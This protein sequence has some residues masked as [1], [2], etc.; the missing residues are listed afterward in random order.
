MLAI[1]WNVKGLGRKEKCKM[2]RNLVLKYKSVVLF[3]Q[4]TKLSSFDSGVIRALGGDVLSRGN[5]V[6]SVGALGGLLSLWNDS[7]FVVNSCVPSK[8]CFFLFG[9]LL[10]IKKVLGMIWDSVVLGVNGVVLQGVL[11]CF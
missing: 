6:G 10:G 3:L 2:V 1:S 4:E 5:G 11:S 7:L 9:E 8:C